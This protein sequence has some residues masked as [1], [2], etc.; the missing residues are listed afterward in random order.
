MSQHSEIIFVCEHGAAKS[1]IA[2]AYFNK[3]ARDRNLSLTA[4]ARGTHPDAELSSKMMTGLR[5]DGLAP[6]EAIPSKLASE[7]LESAKRVVSFCPL[8]EEYHPKA[9]VDYWEDIPPVSEDYESARNAIVI[10][11]NE[12]LSHL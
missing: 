2:A 5:Q 7:D 11:L 6:T 1:I 3:M 12:L 4:I 9:V 8:P 10:H